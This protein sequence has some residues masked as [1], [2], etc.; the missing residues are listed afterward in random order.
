MIRQIPDTNAEDRLTELE[1]FLEFWLGPRC[2]EYGESP[3]K[4]A[5]MQLPDPLRRFYAFAG[6]WPPV[7]P[8]QPARQQAILVLAITAWRRRAAGARVRARRT[9]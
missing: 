5:S 3:E 8:G 7:A 9:R 6:R 2:P 4:L 1:R